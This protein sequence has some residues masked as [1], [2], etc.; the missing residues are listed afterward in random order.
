ML[1]GG[2]EAV[3]DWHQDN[4]KRLTAPLL[5]IA[6][7]SLFGVVTAGLLYITGRV[8]FGLAAGII[9]HLAY[10]VTVVRLLSGKAA[11]N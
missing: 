7:H 10:N 6:G 2:I 3:Y 11:K 5:S 1:F 4:G 8:W 9:V